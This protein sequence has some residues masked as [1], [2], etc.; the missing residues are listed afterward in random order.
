MLEPSGLYYP[1]RIARAFFIAMEDVM[2]RHGLANLLSLADLTA[3][4]DSPP[5]NTLERQFDFA[6][7]AA[8]NEALEGMYGPRGG[9]GM[10]LR[11]G[12]AAFAQGIRHF[13]VM[14]GI[15]DQAFQALPLQQRLD[16][17][18][19]GLAALFTRFSDQESSTTG[20]EH[21]LYFRTEFSPMAWGRRADKP[22]CH[23]MIG[24][25][26]ECLRWSSNGYE[27]Y[28][29]EVS[30]RATGA[31][32]CVFRVNRSAIS[33]GEANRPPRP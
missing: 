3:Y 4:A 29:R 2:G 10:A 26:Q 25:I 32:A 23:A 16:Y 8:L 28:V 24:I 7:M 9:R 5:P 22:V 31:D 14:R 21:A 15:G 33:D 12:R 27:F 19:R 1:N 20:D 13:G 17:G 6:A 18:L 11:I 30:C